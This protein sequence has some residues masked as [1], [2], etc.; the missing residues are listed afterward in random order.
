M[1]RSADPESPHR[2]AAEALG[3]LGPSAFAATD[4]LELLLID[5]DAEV[6]ETAEGALASIRGLAH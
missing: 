2:S 1:L 3:Q 6:R 5:G 4:A